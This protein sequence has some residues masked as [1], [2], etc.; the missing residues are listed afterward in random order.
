MIHVFVPV[1]Y[2]LVGTILKSPITLSPK[3]KKIIHRTIADPTGEPNEE[4]V[5]MVKF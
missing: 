1:I 2:L 4:L 5:P 3:M